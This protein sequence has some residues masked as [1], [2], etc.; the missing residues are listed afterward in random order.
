MDDVAMCIEFEGVAGTGGSLG[1]FDGVL[2]LMPDGDRFG[3]PRCSPVILLTASG[4]PVGIGGGKGDIEIAVT[5]AE[6]ARYTRSDWNEGME[7]TCCSV[8]SLLRCTACRKSKTTYNIS[9]MSANDL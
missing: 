2:G 3:V 8:I 5:E 1:L 4:F 7:S 9:I 6:W